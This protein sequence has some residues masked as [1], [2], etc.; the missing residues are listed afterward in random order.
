MW[1]LRISM[2]VVT[3]VTVAGCGVVADVADIVNGLVWLSGLDVSWLS[4][5]LS[6]VLTAV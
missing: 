2:I 1:K 6:S 4:G 5:V 3:V